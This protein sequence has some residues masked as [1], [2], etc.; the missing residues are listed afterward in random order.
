MRPTSSRLLVLILIVAMVSLALMARLA[1]QP[2]Y[3]LPMNPQDELTPGLIV[4]G[5]RVIL[6][7]HGL[8]PLSPLPHPD[9]D[10]TQTSIPWPDNP[11]YDVILW[12]VQ[13]D[14]DNPSPQWQV[15][16]KKLDAEFIG[17]PTAINP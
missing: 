11:L 8:T 1:R 16:V 3:R 17:W 15:R 4:D 13:T 2:Q 12:Q 5:S 6:Q 10:G 9:G 14:E 7:R